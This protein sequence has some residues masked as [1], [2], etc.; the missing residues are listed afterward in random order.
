MKKQTTRAI[1]LL[2]G[3][4]A[5]S[6]LFF[7]CKKNEITTAPLQA[8]EPAVRTAN[9]RLVFENTTAF[10]KVMEKMD[11]ASANDRD[12]FENRHKFTSFRS[13]A[14]HTGDDD[15]LTEN[16]TDLRRLPPGIQTLLNANGEVQVGDTIIWY[17]KNVKHYI[18][19][20]DEN[21]L[22][23]VKQDPSSSSLRGSYTLTLTAPRSQLVQN[24]V[25]GGMNTPTAEYIYLSNNTDARH[26]RE[27]YQYY[28]AGGT[29]KY[30]HEVG[31]Y[32]DYS[33]IAPNTCGQATYNY[34][35]GCYLYIKLE[36]K[37]RH[38]WN[39]A[40]ETR[41]INYDLSCSG[42]ATVARGCGIVDYLGFF[43][44]PVGSAVQN[45]NLT[46]VLVTRSGL[47]VNS[48]TYFSIGWSLNVSGTIYQH[49]QGDLSSNEWYNT[50][51][52]LW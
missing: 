22:Q 45:S 6:T 31:V 42:N 2:A 16:E 26:Q 25:T 43:S 50:A 49:V 46:L 27:F 28:P 33:Y 35:T 34:Y 48:P 10:Y 3:L 12:A 30:V 7:S 20:A 37:G 24:G 21:R 51:Y 32:T 11:R 47:T 17:N 15:A 44:A 29:R 36:W 23:Q 19:N 39:T 18:P 38:G 5:T 4:L 9:G 40:G 14:N 41:E 8:A 1:H 52:P 13:V